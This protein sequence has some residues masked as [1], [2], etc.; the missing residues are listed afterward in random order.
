MV[1]AFLLL[2]TRKAG[3][4]LLIAST[5]VSAAHPE[6]NARSSRNAQASPVR[7]W[8]SNGLVARTSR[9]AL[10]TCGSS[11]NRARSRPMAAI[12]RIATMKR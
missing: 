4:P 2:G 8:L 7:P 3:T 9:P 5:P 1:A 6:L 11:P 10:S 12:P